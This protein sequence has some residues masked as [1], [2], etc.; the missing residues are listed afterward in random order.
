[1][2]K[3][4]AVFSGE[5]QIVRIVLIVASAR[6]LMQPLSVIRVFDNPKVGFPPSLHP[7][8]SVVYMLCVYADA[9][10]IAE[11]DAQLFLGT[12]SRRHQNLQAI[13]C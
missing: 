8:G 6:A 1:M 12:D 5:N 10:T 11:L 3:I 9:R 2:E 7:L 4:D 13:S